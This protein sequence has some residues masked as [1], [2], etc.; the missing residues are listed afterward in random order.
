MIAVVRYDPEWARRFE[1]ERELL[2]RVLAPW[3]DGG[4]HHVGSTA[5]PGLSAKPI[6]DLVA[7]VCDLED[8]R[9]AAGPLAEH[10]YVDDPHRPGIAH[11][12]AKRAPT[13]R[14]RTA[15]TSPNRAATSGASGSCSATPSA[16]T[17]S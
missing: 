13:G 9:A 10:G 8:A 4:I 12:F 17:R 2:G 1:E 14:R 3:L 7:G 16:P 5:V 15:S 11:H 6:L